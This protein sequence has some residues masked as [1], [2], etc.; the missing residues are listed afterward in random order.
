MELPPAV[1]R[2]SKVAGFDAS[3]NVTTYDASSSVTV[4]SNVTFTQSGSGATSETVSKK[5]QLTS[6]SVWDYLSTAQKADVLAGTML[7]D[8]SDAW[9]R[10]I[11]AAASLQ[12]TE[13][14]APGLAY[15]LSAQVVAGTTLTNGLRFKATGKRDGLDESTSGVVFKYTGSSIC[16]DIRQADGT[17][18]EGNWEW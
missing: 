11:A 9:K 14:E 4:S 17:G 16:W 18:D 13:I 2:A 8:T 15:L 12:V 10:A 3:G 1:E 6:V 7:V 5:L